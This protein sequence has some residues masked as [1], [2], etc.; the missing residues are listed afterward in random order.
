MSEQTSPRPVEE[1][2]PRLDQAP[3]DDDLDD[4]LESAAPRR[5][6]KLTTGLLAG[7]I[8]LIG[9][10]LGSTAEKVVE[11]VQ[12]AQ[13]AAEGEGAETT[14]PDAELPALTGTIQVI[15][16][17]LI[18]VER[19]DGVVVKVVTEPTTLVGLSEAAEMGDL[20]PGDEITVHGERTEDGT[21]T[22]VRIQ[23]SQPP[24]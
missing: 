7:L 13:A 10:F 15:E 9:F 22:A 4:L 19:A 21:L 3:T 1:S 2:T 24:R 6:S 11:A 14:S 12:E 16:D 18:Y 17:G 20:A 5:R 8:F 23:Q